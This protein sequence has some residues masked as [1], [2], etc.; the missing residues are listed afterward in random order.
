MIGEQ[1]TV[2]F[3]HTTRHAYLQRL[4]TLGL[5]PGRR[6]RLRQAQPAFV[7]QVGETELALD[8]QAGSEIFVRR[9]P[10]ASSGGL[11]PEAQ[12]GAYVP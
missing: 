12:Q 2:V 7:V 1:A 10:S 11:H 8:T 9:N 3:V 6:I 5:V 4:S